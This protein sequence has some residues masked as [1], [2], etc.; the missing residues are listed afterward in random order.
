G[1]S[2]SLLLLDIDH[3]KNLNDA[4]GHGAGDAIL[5]G[6][7]QRVAGSIRSVD[8]VARYG[9]EEFAVVCPELGPEEAYGL[10]SHLHEAIRDAGF[11]V[12]DGV[13]DVR[14]SIGVASWPQ[15]ATTSTELMRAADAALSQAKASGR[16]RVAAATV[17]H[18]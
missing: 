13:V 14:V 6:M 3:F 12:E 5:H 10:A 9:G 11:P 8:T 2:V 1:R 16:D 15:Q 17:P 7:A 4:H 18:R